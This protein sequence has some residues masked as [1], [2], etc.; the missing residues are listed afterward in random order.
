[1]RIAALYHPKSEYEGRVIDYA[2]EYHA[3][4]PGRSIELVSLDTK[5]GAEMARLYDVT[6]YPAVLVIAADGALQ[7]LWQ[8]GTSADLLPQVSEIDAYLV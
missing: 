7:N 4:H 3:R 2:R 5:Q 1:M 8:G 6:R